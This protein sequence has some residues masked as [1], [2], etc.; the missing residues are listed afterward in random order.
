[1]KV[2]ESKEQKCPY[3]KNDIDL[4]IPDVVYRHAQ[5]YGGGRVRFRCNR[6][7]KVIEAFSKVTI[8]VCGFRKTYKESDW[9][10]L[11]DNNGD[12]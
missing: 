5:S 12:N 8:D 7:G 9:P 6:C 10:H 2:L 4:C 11:E 1:M 3:C